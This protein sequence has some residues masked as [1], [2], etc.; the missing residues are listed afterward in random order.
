[1]I[2]LCKPFFSLQAIF[3]F[4]FPADLKPYLIHIIHYILKRYG[5]ISNIS[6]SKSIHNFITLGFYFVKN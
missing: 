4:S 5:F 3:T 1:M 2:L 6:V